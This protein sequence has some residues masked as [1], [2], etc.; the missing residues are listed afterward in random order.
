M[1]MD[2]RH[3]LEFVL[4][5]D[6][7]IHR[8]EKG[9]WIK[10][11]IRCVE[12][13]PPRPNGLIYSMTLHGPG[14]ERIM[15]FDNAHGVRRSGYRKDPVET[16]HWHRTEMDPGRPYRFTTVD[17]LLADFFAEVRRVVDE[18]G[19]SDEVIDVEERGH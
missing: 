6:G 17:Q 10:F 11:E 3:T 7:R 16:D 18:R 4:A 14:G 5:F 9:Y 15:G 1:G 2:D 13:S 19:I 12:P 8:L